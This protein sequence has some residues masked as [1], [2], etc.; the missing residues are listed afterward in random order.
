MIIATA[1]RF[2]RLLVV[3]VLIFALVTPSGPLSLTQLV[4]ILV[5]F[6][7]LLLLILVLS[8]LILRPILGLFVTVTLFL[9]VLIEG[10]VAILL[11]EGLHLPLIR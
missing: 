5:L 7:V 8:I 4:F 11:S 1:I 9:H 10:L 3:V 2:H 6:L